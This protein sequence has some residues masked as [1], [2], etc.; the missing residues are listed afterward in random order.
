MITITDRLKIAIIDRL[1][2]TITDRFFS[3]TNRLQVA[4]ATSRSLVLVAV[5][6]RA[7]NLLWNEGWLRLLLIEL[8]DY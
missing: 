1:R 6:Y 5:D 7:Y 3:I 2:I 4:T 8:K